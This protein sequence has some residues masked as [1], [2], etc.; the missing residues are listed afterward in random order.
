M[1]SI[2]SRTLVISFAFA[3]TLLLAL[4]SRTLPVHAAA[5][6]IHVFS[7]ERSFSLDVFELDSKEYVNLGAALVSI[8]PTISRQEG[9][10]LHLHFGTTEIRLQN[11]DANVKVGKN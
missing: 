7:H 11:N 3:A 10:Q 4:L 2:N 9:V 1:R 8:G 6:P 5:K